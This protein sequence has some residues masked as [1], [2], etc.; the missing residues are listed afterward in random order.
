MWGAFLIAG[1]A[2]L[3]SAMFLHA[4]VAVVAYLLSGV[5]WAEHCKLTT[6]QMYWLEDGRPFE[7][8]ALSRS[9]AAMVSLWPLHSLQRAQIRLRRLRS[10]VRFQVVVSKLDSTSPDQQDF[11]A[12]DDA[13]RFAQQRAKNLVPPKVKCSFPALG[14]D[15]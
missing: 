11:G 13:L 15:L 12:W 10:P 6:P 2:C 7:P 3:G 5:F 14:S 4:G 9:F 8:E 1:V